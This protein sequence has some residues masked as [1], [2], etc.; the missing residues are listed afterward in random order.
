MNQRKL[1]FGFSKVVGTD[2][3]LRNDPS[4]DKA[5]LHSN[6]GPTTAKRLT[7]FGLFTNLQV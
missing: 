4:P 5:L 7:N 1:D 2:A 6:M 3:A